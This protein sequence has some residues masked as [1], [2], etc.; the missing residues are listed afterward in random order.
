MPFSKDIPQRKKIEEVNFLNK[1]KE[2]SSGMVRLLVLLYQVGTWYWYQVCTR[3]GPGGLHSTTGTGT[4]P[5]TRM[6]VLVLHTKIV[7]ELT[8]QLGR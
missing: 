5:G 3:T 6:V 2:G 7:M 1:K 8:C 4:C